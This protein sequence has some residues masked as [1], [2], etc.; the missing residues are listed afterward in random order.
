M[1][2]CS[3]GLVI[4]LMKVYGGKK[5]TVNL[6]GTNFDSF[7]PAHIK[8]SLWS[9]QMDSLFLQDLITLLL[10]CFCNFYGKVVIISHFLKILFLLFLVAANIEDRFLDRMSLMVIYFFAWFIFPFFH[11]SFLTDKEFCML[12][13]TQPTVVFNVWMWRLW[14]FRNGWFSWIPRSF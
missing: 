7:A 6:F 3:S 4:A 14:N 5:W 9:F 12:H 11:M 8:K 2:Y 13:I 1:H 10:I